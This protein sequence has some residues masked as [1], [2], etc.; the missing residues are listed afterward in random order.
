LDL[1]NGCLP[2]KFTLKAWFKYRCAPVRETKGAPPL[3]LDTRLDLP[4]GHNSPN[5]S[6]CLDNCKNVTL[7]SRY[8]VASSLQTARCV[9]R[10]A[11]ACAADRAVIRP[12]GPR[13][14]H[15]SNPSHFSEKAEY[16]RHA[17]AAA[18]PI[19]NQWRQLLPDL[20]VDFPSLELLRIRTAK[21]AGAGRI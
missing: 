7:E 6:L 11:G 20:R 1:P 13:R 18:R 2:A 14:H 9:S 15:R 17:S 8:G 19:S 12:C 5:F 4:G 10:T 16:R 21:T 3:P